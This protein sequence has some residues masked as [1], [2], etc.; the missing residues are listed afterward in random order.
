MKFRKGDTLIEVALATGIFSLVAITVVSVVNGSTSSI[1]S[2]LEVTVTREEIDAQAEALRF[3]HNAALVG[4]D[5]GTSTS[6]S[7]NTKYRELWNAITSLATSNDT[8]LVYNP[9]TCNELYA[10]NAQD[11][12]SRG[13]FVLNTRKMDTANVSDIVYSASNYSGQFKPAS[14]YP[15]V[16]HASYDESVDSLYNQGEGTGFY[17]AEG[18]FI[19]PFKDKGSKVVTGSSSSLQNK[20]A[21]Y[22]FYIRTCWYGPG[23]DKPST[24]STVVRLYDPD[25]INY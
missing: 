19:V 13:A 2:A 1:Q 17:R 25:V 10:D 5:S 7:T 11:L 8:A 3:I 18:I 9:K 21:Y 16:I 24:I 6:I 12:K 4:D 14:T 20:A 23:A 22:D 15:R